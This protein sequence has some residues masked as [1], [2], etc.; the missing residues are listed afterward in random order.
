[1]AMFEDQDV[2]PKKSKEEEASAPAP[3]VS[4]RRSSV[5]LNEPGQASEFARKS[6]N[7]QDWGNDVA[8]EK[9]LDIL[10]QV[11]SE[12]ASQP[13]FVVDNVGMLPAEQ[14]GGDPTLVWMASL[15]DTQTP[16]GFG[17]KVSLE[18][19][20]YPNAHVAKRRADGAIGCVREPQRSEILLSPMDC[21]SLS[22]RTW[23]NWA[24]S[25]GVSPC[26]ARLCVHR[27]LR[28]PSLSH[29]APHVRKRGL[30][31]MGRRIDAPRSADSGGGGGCLLSVLAQATR[32]EFWAVPA[33][34]TAQLAPG[35]DTPEA[36]D[37][38]VSV[39]YRKVRAWA[40]LCVCCVLVE[41]LGF[42]GVE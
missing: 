23:I 12:H 37:A 40:P 4:V 5:S 34:T 3:D 28:C 24:S 13:D 31:R 27:M 21:N 38:F 15:T 1:M 22:L 7:E 33:E 25:V 18:R 16:L 39:L 20:R 6:A 32:E 9:L 19:R 42:S 26:G 10:T 30:C 14:D 2:S 35:L 11:V 17:R 36:V 29:A 8:L 41:R